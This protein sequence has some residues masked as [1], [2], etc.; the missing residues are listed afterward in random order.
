MAE[1]RN[2]VV[3]A[4]HE[5]RPE[6]T[7]VLEALDDFP[8]ELA[9]RLSGFQSAEDLFLDVSA[10]LV[11]VDRFLGEGTHCEGSGFVDEIT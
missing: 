9:A 3:F 11:R 5:V 4:S 10:E 1:E 2:P 6:G 8:I 7:P